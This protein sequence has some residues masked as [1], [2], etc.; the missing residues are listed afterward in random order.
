M[1]AD[2]PHSHV[3]QT[4]TS[5]TTLD[6]FGSKSLTSSTQVR[7]H[8]TITAIL[9]PR[10]D[11]RQSHSLPGWLYCPSYSSYNGILQPPWLAPRY[12]S[13]QWKCVHTWFPVCTTV[14]W[15][16]PL[17]LLQPIVWLTF[18]ALEWVLRMP[19]LEVSLFNHQMNEA[20]QEE[21]SQDPKP[22]ILYRSQLAMTSVILSI[23]VEATLTS[24]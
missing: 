16:S 11:T 17:G 5:L 7:G 22:R 15:P 14:F 8:A 3:H 20:W 2:S 10:P 4:H 1:L 21:G 23:F 19:F 6:R 24:E 18:C 9:V 12:Y 13:Y